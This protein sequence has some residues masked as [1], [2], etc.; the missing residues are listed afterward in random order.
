MKAMQRTALVL[1][2]SAGLI[3][4]ASMSLADEAPAKDEH[5]GHHTE[6]APA[7]AAPVTASPAVDMQA[8]RDRMREIRQTADPEKRKALIEAQMHDMEAM[9][10]DPKRSCPKAD[11]KAGMGMMGG[12][13]GKGMMG[14]KGGMGGMGGMDMKGGKCGK[15]MMG[16]K[17]GMGDM[18]MKGGKCAK[19]M[20]GGKGGM[21]M[22]GQDD[23]MAKRMEM[24]EKRMDMM[25]M[26]MQM[27]MQGM[28]GGMGMSAN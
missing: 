22:S 14:D 4:P 28:G 21:N 20:M 23:M 13:C 12:K 1:A 26:M 10:N 3:L 25:Q 18:D 19:G 7:T 8:M 11:G 6:V 2:L 17:G 9:V 24:M 27:R 15:G 16:D 5:A